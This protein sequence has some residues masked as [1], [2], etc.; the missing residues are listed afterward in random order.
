MRWTQTY[1]LD[2]DIRAVQ[3]NAAGVEDLDRVREGP[4]RRPNLGPL[5]RFELVVDDIEAA[6]D[7]PI[8]TSVAV[9]ELFHLD[10]RVS[11][12]P[13]TG[14]SPLLTSRLV[15]RPD[16][17]ADCSRR[18]GNGSGAGAEKSYAVS[19]RVLFFLT[20]TTIRDPARRRLER[21]R[22]DR[23][24]GVQSLSVTPRGKEACRMSPG[25]SPSRRIEATL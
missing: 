1:V 23:P 20:C 13:R 21:A 10:G 16:R 18:S 6:R 11:F 2:D 19:L 5:E 24:R 25:P 15:Q 22:K 12:G 17:A 14:A 3:L 7:D 4:G 9:R 8:G